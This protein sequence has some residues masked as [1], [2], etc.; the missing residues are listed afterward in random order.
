MNGIARPWLRAFI[1]LLVLC[2]IVGLSVF[3][4]SPWHKHSRFSSTPCVFSSLE[5]GACD[6]VASHVLPIR[7]PTQCV[8]LSVLDQPTPVSLAARG[9]AS[10]RAPPAL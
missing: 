4:F 1:G 8:W 6:G 5:H 2:S 10:V 3:L 9:E 7:P